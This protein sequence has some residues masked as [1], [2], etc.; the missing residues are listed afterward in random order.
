[1]YIPFLA[2]PIIIKFISASRRDNIY[3]QL[4][5]TTL[6]KRNANRFSLV[7]VPLVLLIMSFPTFLVNHSDI[8]TISV[9]E[10]EQSAGEFVS[11]YYDEEE[12]LFISDII[13]VYSFVYYIPDAE[14]SHPAQSWELENE[15]DLWLSFQKQIDKF[16]SYPGTAILA[17]TERFS[18]PYRSIFGLENTSPQWIEFLDELSTSDTI[19]NNGH[20]QIYINQS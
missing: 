4:T 18:Q 6:E 19:Y 13:T 11:G 17:V 15:D 16:E 9:Y 5:N 1:M 2:V 14:M 8:D 12:L 3:M 10:Y 7:A 20:I